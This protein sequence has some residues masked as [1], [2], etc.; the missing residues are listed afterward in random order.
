M[1]GSLRYYGDARMNY[2]AQSC[3]VTSTNNV[4]NEII[5]RRGQD[6]CE[7]QVLLITIVIVIQTVL[8][9][10]VFTFYTWQM[11]LKKLLLLESVS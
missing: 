9:S 11:G 7:K 5:A 8:Y 6:Q 1:N 2:G 3:D 10:L 4:V